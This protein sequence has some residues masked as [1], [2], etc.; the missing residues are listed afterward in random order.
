MTWLPFDSAPRDGTRILVATW[1][2]HVRVGFVDGGRCLDDGEC[3]EIADATHWMPLPEH[4]RGE[5][6]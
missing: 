4:P 5:S 2:G 1:G 3:R 6:R